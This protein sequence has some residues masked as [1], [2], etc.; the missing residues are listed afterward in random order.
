[1]EGYGDRGKT[2]LWK[3]ITIKFHSE[4]KVVLAVASC[5]IAALLLQRG[6]Y[7]CREVSRFHTRLILVEESTCDIKQGTHL[8]E[9]INK[10]SLILWYEAPTENKICRCWIEP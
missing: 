6:H 3:A 8:A 10:A 9:L 2:Y 4:G 5:G 1:M 7:F